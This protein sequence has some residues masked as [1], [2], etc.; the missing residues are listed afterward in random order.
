MTSDQLFEVTKSLG[1]AAPLVV[2]L[3]YLLRLVVELLTKAT[4]ERKTITA[5]F[6]D[7]MKTTA[8]TSALAQQQAAASLQELAAAMRDGA[9]RSLEEHNRI[10]DAI[11]KLGSRR[12]S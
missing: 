7:A 1:I 12:D 8:T 10:V 5:Q 11:G 2:V 6:V 3:L 9:S 4:D